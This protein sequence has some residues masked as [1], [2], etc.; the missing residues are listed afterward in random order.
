MTKFYNKENNILPTCISLCLVVCLIFSSLSAYTFEI[1]FN[2]NANQTTFTAAQLE[3]G[4]VHHTAISK[5]QLL[6]ELIDIEEE[7]D[8]NSHFG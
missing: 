5:N 4:F 2:N 3:Q 7:E 1:F 6:A 8:E